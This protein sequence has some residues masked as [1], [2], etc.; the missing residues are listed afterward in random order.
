MNTLGRLENEP[1]GR[2]WID[3]RHEIYL[4]EADISNLAQAKAANIAGI[5]IL[6]ERYGVTIG[7]VDKFYL[8]G[9]FANYVNIEHAIRIGMIPE[10]ARGKIEKIGN[11]AIEGATAMLCSTPLRRRMEQ[12][13][14]GVGHV[15][16][17]KH[18]NFFGVFVEGCQFKSSSE[19]A[20]SLAGD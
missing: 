16:L 20:G 12:F 9:G 14:R 1:G 10:M 7:Q 17:E 13:V 6:L 19:M 3:R 18:E 5:L 2:F 8:A 11:A 15:E 4:S